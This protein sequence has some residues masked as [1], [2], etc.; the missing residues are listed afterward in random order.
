[1]MNNPFLRH[2]D[3]SGSF[4]PAD[5]VQRKAE[6]R[7]N[8]ICLT[9]FGVVMFGIVGAF[10]VTNRQWLQVKQ[11]RQAITVQ[12]TQQASRIEQLKTLEGQKAEMMAKAEITTA[13]IEKVPR[14]IMM[15]ELVSRMPADMALLELHLV[16]KRI[17]E[18][19]PVTTPTGGK[20]AANTQI[21]TLSGKG[22]PQKE[23][24]AAAAERVAPPR[25]EYTLK[26]IGVARVNNDIADYLAA[27][28]ACS[29]LDKVELKYIK[30]ATIDKQDFRQFELEAVLRR[31]A[32]ARGVE[33]M[34]EIRQAMDRS[35]VGSGGLPEKPRTTEK[36][37][38]SVTPPKGDQ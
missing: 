17:R 35:S 32:D 13:L 8:G 28:K 36:P 15:G 29:L 18:A 1:M 31:D 23:G 19:T 7:A 30:Q 26:L 33:P 3:Q 2:G 38:T 24:G 14:S 4:L 11:E 5:Y 10:F 21:R 6:L 27:L 34:P 22:T 12:Y 16:S 25:F 20:P 9:L 37:V